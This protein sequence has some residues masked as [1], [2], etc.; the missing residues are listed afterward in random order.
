MKVTESVMHKISGFNFDIISA[1]IVFFGPGGAQWAIEPTGGAEIPKIKFDIFVSLLA[2]NYSIII[3][4]NSDLQI[5]HTKGQGVLKYQD[6]ETWVFLLLL[7]P[8][9]H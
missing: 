4:G 8:A 2:L 1:Q 9:N 6:I 7:K 3:P 5:C